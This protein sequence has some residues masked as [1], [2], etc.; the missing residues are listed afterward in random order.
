[1]AGEAD[2]KP[3]I[4]PAPRD[5]RF[6]DP[7]WKYEPVLRFHPSAL[8]ADLQMGAGAGQQRRGNRSAHAQEG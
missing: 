1:M 7:E 3:A 6:Q 2:A 8:S 4:A 5:K